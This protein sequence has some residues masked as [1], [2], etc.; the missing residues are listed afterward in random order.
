MTCA[1]D[2]RMGT[3]I[4]SVLCSMSLLLT[5][6]SFSTSFVPSRPLATAAASRRANRRHAPLHAASTAVTCWINHRTRRSQATH[7]YHRACSVRRS[8]RRSH[9]IGRR[10][11]LAL[12]CVVYVLVAPSIFNTP[13]CRR[14][15]ALTTPTLHDL[16][17][18]PHPD[19][20]VRVQRFSQ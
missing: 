18:P 14:L 19:Q 3:E 10:H 15:H 7:T 11:S 16:Q 9:A 17:Q 1:V 20:R 8:T 6:A 5:L 2:G 4:E 13:S 12:S